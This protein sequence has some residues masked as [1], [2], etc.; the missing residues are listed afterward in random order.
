MPSGPGSRRE[1]PGLRSARHD[2]GWE[3]RAIGRPRPGGIGRL[4]VIAHDLMVS[5]NPV[6]GEAIVSRDPSTGAEIPPHDPI[7][8]DEINL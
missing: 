8:N 5:S 6:A 3:I 7:G 2:R 1:P 4:F